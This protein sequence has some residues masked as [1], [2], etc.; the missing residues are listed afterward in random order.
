MVG[1]MSLYFSEATE[2]H[3]RPLFLSWGGVREVR[4]CAG[5]GLASSPSCGFSRFEIIL[6]WEIHCDEKDLDSERP[7]VGVVETW[8]ES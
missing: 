3:H 1:Q 4:S 2:T 5:A 8:S 7:W 6:V